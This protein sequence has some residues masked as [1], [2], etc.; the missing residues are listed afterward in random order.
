MNRV[1]FLLCLSVLISDVDRSNLSL[2]AP[3]LQSELGISTIQMGTLLSTFFWTYA[4]MQTHAGWLV[5]RFDVKWV[6]TIGFF[7]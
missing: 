4:L 7:V 1:L 3:L 2:A 6:F 5:D